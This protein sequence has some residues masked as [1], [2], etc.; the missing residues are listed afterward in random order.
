MIDSIDKYELDP[1]IQKVGLETLYKLKSDYEDKFYEFLIE[2]T[3]NSLTHLN[4][5]INGGKY[6]AIFSVDVVLN[7]SVVEIT[8]KIQLI[9][10]A[11]NKLIKTILRAMKDIN[12]WSKLNDKSVTSF[13]ERVGKDHEIVKMIFILYGSFESN[14]G[15]IEKYIKET[16]DP[17]KP[18]WVDSIE[19]RIKEFNQKANKT[20]VDYENKLKEYQDIK[21]KIL[22]I[23]EEKQI[24]AIALNLTQIKKSLVHY[25]TDWVT[26]YTRQ[27]LLTTKATHKEIDQLLTSLE[28]K[29]AIKV[30]KIDELKEVVDAIEE[31]RSNEG[32][33][34]NKLKPFVLLY[35]LVKK[36]LSEADFERYH[37]PRKEDFE[38][39]WKVILQKAGDMR[40]TLQKDQL[41]FKK[42]LYQDAASLKNAIKLLDEDYQS[43]G[44][45]QEKSIEAAYDKLETFRRKVQNLLKFRANIQ[46]GEKIFN[47][48]QNQ[49]EKLTKI[50]TELKYQ[51][52]LYDLYMKVLNQIA[53]WKELQFSEFKD[54]LDKIDEMDNK[55][56][57]F[58]SGSLKINKEVKKN[59]EYLDL[60]KDLERLALILGA[61]RL[62]TQPLEEHHWKSLAEKT[63]IKELATVISEGGSFRLKVLFDQKIEDF[64]NEI[65]ETVNLA[66]TQK[67]VRK[68]IEDIDKDWATRK[69]V[70]EPHKTIKDLYLINGIEA[71]VIKVLVEDNAA[72]IASFKAQSRNLTDELRAKIKQE[73][74][75]FQNINNTLELWLNVQQ[76]WN[77]L[78]SFFIGGDIR[79][80]LPG[81]TSAFDNCHKLFIKIMMDKAY[82]TQNVKALCGTNELG[83]DLVIIDGILK[84][85][86]QKLDVYLEKKRKDFPR[87]Y[88]VSNSVLLEI[89]SKRSDPGNIKS[90]LNIMFDAL[91]D[92]EFNENDKKTIIKIRQLRSAQ[93]PDDV[94]EVSI[95]KHPVKCDGNIETWLGVLVESM[96][97]SLQ[98]LF[99]VAYNEIK[100]FFETPLDNENTVSSFEAFITKFI[101]QVV[102]FGLHLFGTKRLEEFIVR[103]SEKGEF[104]KK[105]LSK[106]LDPSM[107]DFEAILLS[108]TKMCKKDNKKKLEVVKLEALIII[109][110]HNIDIYDYFVNDKETVGQVTVNDYN[111]LKQTRVYWYSH[112]NGVKKIRTCLINITDVAFEYGYEFLGA[113]E[114]MCITPLT[115][116]CYITL[117]QAMGMQYGG[118]P[119][120]PAGTGKTETVKDMGRSMGVFV[121]VTNCAPEHRYKNMAEIFKGLCQSG[122][123]GCFDEF[124]RIQLEVLSVLATIINAIQ[125]CRRKNEP[126][127]PFPET[128]S[129]TA[130]IPLDYCMGYFITMNP[131]YSGRQELPENLKI[132]FRGVTMM[133]ANRES[134]IRVKLCSYGFD[135][136][137]DLA[138]KFRKL[139]ELCEAQ[140]SKQ[141]HYDFGLRNILSVLRHAGNEKKLVTEDSAAK[142]EELLFKALRG[143]NLSK[144]VPDDK[145]LFKQLI[146]DV[147]PAQ[148]NT[149][150]KKYPALMAKI[151]KV[152]T[153]YKL[154]DYK[155]WVDKIIQ[156]YETYFVRHGFMIVGTTGTGKTTIMDVL[157]EAMSDLEAE[158]LGKDAK[159]WRI[160][161]LNPKAVENEYLFIQKIEDTYILGVFTRIWRECNVVTTATTPSYNWIVCDGPIDSLWIENLNTVLDDNKILT[162]SNNERISML[163]T[164]RL[165]MECENVKN[166]S[167]ATVSR[168][169]MIY[170]TESDITY[171]PYINS[172][173]VVNKDLVKDLK[174]DE[175][176]KFGDLVKS[177]ISP[178]VDD[179]LMRNYTPCIELSWL[180]KVKNYLLLL[181]NLL[182]Q[183][184][185]LT[186]L[187]R[188]KK[189]IAFSFAWGI[190]SLYDIQD[191]RKIHQ[192][193]QKQGF[194][195]N[196]LKKDDGDRTIFESTLEEDWSPWRPDEITLH[197]KDVENFSSLLIPT[198]D[199]QRAIF[200]IKQ[201]AKSPIYIENE[202]S[203]PCL[204]LGDS[205][206]AKTSTILIFQKEYEKEPK[207]ALKRVNFS[208]ATSPTNFQETVDD[209][210]DKYGN[211]YMP[212]GEKTMTIFIDD[213]SMPY[214]NKWGDQVTLELVRQLLEFGGYYFLTNG[215][216]R[217]RMKPIA[218]VSFVAAMNHPKGGKNDIPNRLK[219]HFF[220][221]NMVLPNNQSVSD[222]Y[223]KICDAFFTKKA[224]NE[225][226]MNL[227]KKLP[228][229]TSDL[230]KRMANK[231]QPTP[232][233]FHYYYNMR[234][235]SRTFQGLFKTDKEAMKD[236][237]KKFGISNEVYLFAFW[238]HEVTR[239]FCDK[240]RDLKDKEE[241]FNIV[242]IVLSENEFEKEITDQLKKEYLFADYLAEFCEDNGYREYPK[243]YEYVNMEN[244]KA[245][246]TNFMTE[247]NTQKNRKHVEIELFDD[248]L[249]NLMRITR[250]IQQD[251]GSCMIVGVGGSGKQSLTRLAAYCEQNILIQ[252]TYGTPARPDELRLFFREAFTKIIEDYNPQKGIFFIPH[253][254]LMTDAEFKIDYYLEAVSSFLSTG[255]I[256]NLFNQKND[257]NAVIAAM[258]NTL[259]KV[260]GETNAELDEGAVWIKLIKYARQFLHMCLCFSPSSEKFRDKFIKFPVLFNNCT[261]MWMFPWPEDALI[262]V[263]SG[264]VKNNENLHLIGKPDQITTL[265]QHIANVHTNISQTV[266][267][268]YFELFRRYVY[269]TPKSFLS[270][271]DEYVKI[272][273]K[274]NEEISKKETTINTGLSKLDEA[275]EDIKIKNQEMEG[276][277][278]IVKKAKDEVDAKEK[279]LNIKNKDIEKVE[280][281]VSEKEEKC[282]KEKDEIEAENKIVQAELAKAK[283]ILEDAE[284][285]IIRMDKDQLMRV[286]GLNVPTSIKF[287]FECAAV[288]MG[289]RI[290]IV[291]N[292]G[293]V[294]LNKEVTTKYYFPLGWPVVSFFVKQTGESGFF[295]TIADWN[296]KLKTNDLNIN[297]ETLELLI[298][299]LEAANA[300]GE[301]LFDDSLATSIGGLPCKLLA[302]FCRS[303]S[304]YVYAVRDVIPKQQKVNIMAQKYDEAMRKLNIE[305][306]N[307]ARVLADKKVLEDE[308]AII[309]ESQER[310]TENLNKMKKKVD[311]AQHLIN[312]LA[313]EKARWK[314]DSAMFDQQKKQL[315]GDC[316][317]A[318]AFIAYSGP[319]NSTFRKTI[320]ENK[321][322]RGDIEKKNIPYSGENLKVEQFLVEETT[323][324]EWLMSKLPNDLLSTQN[325]ILVTTSSR[326]PLIIDPQDQAKNWLVNMYPTLVADK[327]IYQ[328]ITFCGKNFG[329]DCSYLLGQDLQIIIE[330]IENDVDTTLDVILE[331]QFIGN[332]NSKLKRIKLPDREVDFNDKF[333]MFLLCKLISPHF[334]PELAAKTTII[335]FC[336]TSE[337]LTQQLQAVVISKEQKSLEETLKQILSDIRR[338]E[339]SL[340]ECQEEILKNLNQKGSL[341]ENEAIVG[342]LNNS[343][344]QAEDNKKKIAEAKDKE[345]DIN[346]KREKYKP[347][348]ARGS[349]LYF[350]IVQMQEISKMYSTS[351]QQFLVLFDF[352]I[353]HAIPSNN[354]EQRVKNIM[355][356]LTEHVYKYIVRG[357][358]ERDKT[359]FI[360]IVCFKILTEE[361]V[362]GKPILK[363]GDINFFIKC[364]GVINAAKEADCPYDFLGSKTD[365]KPKEYLNLLAISRRKFNDSIVYFQKL[366]NKLQDEPAKFKAFYNS[367]EA[368]TVIPYEETLYNNLNKKLAEFLK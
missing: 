257:K 11:I 233:K 40:D 342:V 44:P 309:K 147:F 304:K 43:H 292:F 321:V 368:E 199:S 153:K 190:G 301:K 261:I 106:E 70:F 312:S 248:C 81:P 173:L 79:K 13:H 225:N 73:E 218:K 349:V 130:Q 100:N 206:T 318:S 116:K 162:L 250:V 131:G 132:L 10:E 175:K 228:K 172:W 347:V 38:L 137:D 146:A 244:V 89:L 336:V 53:E 93:A 52:S 284:Q 213:L 232:V 133:S 245:V 105:Q 83:P 362:E 141:Q 224:F 160:H 262:S 15:E 366:Q 102:I 274:K 227:S 185:K 275:E 251:Q 320:L 264:K 166:A 115:D 55:Y 187:K 103:T 159:K 22:A 355:K 48:T 219:R 122:A 215:E 192:Y 271:I 51:G 168:C 37:F 354:T 183:E 216:E 242:D 196:D 254:M 352:A 5:R 169:G 231:F 84:G 108:L 273:M 202:R 109:H 25:C 112:F 27:L 140:L 243:N 24:G 127:F 171:I 67:N 92:I 174:A 31:I 2:T 223:G 46:S 87:F 268:D 139:Y 308:L 266:C 72:T 155:D 351:L 197:A 326:Y 111:W 1:K 300:K 19:K 30:E 179:Y 313:D 270:F 4:N 26:A 82:P 239:V 181:R 323:K 34:E 20:F 50:D 204:L 154:D 118:A 150:E 64:T 95:A 263:V 367:Q 260:P 365:K 71:L 9:H 214:V 294:A 74:T 163:D 285:N 85:C 259:T 350:S 334:T 348:A 125:E 117:A 80:D 234:E 211:E 98:D 97:L 327:H 41:N 76:L 358:F 315:L 247:L 148:Q 345:L 322:F 269:V 310:Q 256:A 212:S 283:P 124:N 341:L 158:E 151:K 353:E 364:G 267:K 311:S 198:M 123:W 241:F 113:K 279:I 237:Q 47:V 186:D 66:K 17:F 306:E 220:I 359:A 94:Q 107:K 331:K 16:F 303:I 191:R 182:S 200:L 325:A 210:L 178:E 49:Y 343:K 177:L 142:E 361:D 32:E 340:L 307:K 287:Y 119:A 58:N 138:K 338:N 120:G 209:E 238:K 297:D 134:I 90:N 337:G 101:C 286:T 57:E 114:R 277:M 86:Q 194:P 235:L 14:H 296:K 65:E 7:S 35:N 333:K 305:K 75:T 205:G 136:H 291:D 356:R 99:E 78:Q 180:I 63:G 281:E 317:V 188:I 278:I 12:S 203:T 226:I 161:R 289:R 246:T 149:P 152:L 316:A 144:L 39:K 126:E 330:G 193:L 346:Q 236:S 104:G 121:L 21:A 23:P 319:F 344:T 28:T 110:V 363:P 60:K 176:K 88:F 128:A 252:P 59:K 54:K 290:G 332:K 249:A 288:I 195:L 189:I 3:K 62:L 265:F 36:N 339:N 208:S 357:L 221:F 329:N 280:K 295:A 56:S 157:T 324:N 8:P 258:R 302:A 253:T 61:F 328:M 201:I 167:L 29:L 272:Y 69:F 18:I 293:D 77:S 222:I 143:M 314:I 230:L 299:F 33:I 165:I 156:T 217:G 229:L 164:C 282:L 91:N 360:L 6:N 45:N 298:P 184:N 255:E 207:H 145:D 240:L 170:I 276:Q 129:T 135:C 68:R 335:D 42:K 96:K